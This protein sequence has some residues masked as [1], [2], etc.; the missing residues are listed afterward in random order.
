[1]NCLTVN[2][3]GAG[4]K[5]KADWVKKMKIENQIN[6]LSCQETQF[7]DGEQIRIENFWDGSDFE[8]AIVDAIGRSGGLFCAVEC[9]YFEG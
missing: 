8:C 2:L 9:E 4:D 7:A 6:F 1:M 3:R 5:R